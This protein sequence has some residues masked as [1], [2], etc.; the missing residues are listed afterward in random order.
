MKLEHFKAQLEDGGRSCP[1][2]WADVLQEPFRTGVGDGE[3]RLKG[4]PRL[5]VDILRR[6]QSRVEIQV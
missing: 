5:R 2:S 1:G 4:A 3:W 6:R